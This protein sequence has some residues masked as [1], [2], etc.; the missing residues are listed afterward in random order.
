VNGAHVHATNGDIGHVENLLADDA[1]WDIRYLIVAT[2]NWWFGKHVLLSPYAVVKVG[3]SDGEV[4]LNVT[5]DQVKSS[6]PWDPMKAIE[7]IEEEQL[8]RHYG[9]RGYGW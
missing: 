1:N 4:W 3:W 2:R 8:H 9:W 6:P 5:R 7:R